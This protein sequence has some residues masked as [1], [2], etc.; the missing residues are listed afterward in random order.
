MDELTH[1][2][3]ERFGKRLELVDFSQ[4]QLENYQATVL[5]I[6]NAAPVF[7]G[8]VLRTVPEAITKS[9]RVVAA[10]KAGVLKGMT[11]ESVG[12]A[13]PR[14]VYWLADEIDDWIEE[15]KTIPP[16]TA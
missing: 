15:I 5:E 16:E 12:E 2:T 8:T 9:A 10:L 4:T 13:S 6:T 7:A 11:P 3:L 1:K 14:L